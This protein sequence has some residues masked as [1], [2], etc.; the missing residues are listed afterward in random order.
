MT[1][2]RRKLIQLSALGGGLSV[3]GSPLLAA[4]R[5]NGPVAK[6]PRRRV[7]RR[8]I[9]LDF[10]T[11][12]YLPD[13]GKNFSKEQFQHSLKLANVDAVN[14]FAKGHHSWSYYP[15]KVGR[16]H[17][18]LKFDLLGEQIQACHEIGVAA[19]IYY[20]FGWS[21]N[22]AVNHPEWC[23]RLEDG[24]FQT[25][26]DFNWD[27]KPNDSKP[28]FHWI[29][30]CVNTSYH[31]H[32]MAQVEELCVNYEV[33]GLWLDIYQVS[34]PCYC[35]TC[36]K[37]MRAEGIDVSKESDVIAFLARSFKRHQGALTR[38]IQSYHPTATVYFNGCSA[39]NR[40][41]HNFKYE[42]YEYNTV[43]DLEDLPTTW[44]GYD[45]L[46]IQSKFFINA[47]YP[48][49]AMSGKFHTAWG[50]FGGF[51]SR[52]ALRYE[53]SAMIS[54]GA[55]C[56]FGDQLHP[57]G[58]MDLDTYKNIGEAY[59][60][61]E[62]IEDYGIGGTPEARVGVWR[63]FSASHDEGTCRILLER[64][65]NFDIANV[66]DRDLTAYDV[67]VIP[68]VAC[69]SANDARRIKAFIATGGSILVMGA[70]A[71]DS[72]NQ[73]LVVDIGARLVGESQYD[74]DYL[75][76][77]KALGDG[78]VESPFLC[79]EPALRVTAA[80]DTEVL[81]AVREPYFS[82][83]YEKFTSHQNTPFQL[84]DAP[85][86]GV[87]RKGNV[88]FIAHALDKMYFDHG[89]RL[90]RDLFINA[91]RLV[92]RRPMIETELPS[93]GRVSLLHQQDK[94]RFVV[95][96]LYGPPITRGNCE[97]IE[98][99]PTLHSVPVVLDL[100]KTITRA[101]LVPEM[102][103]LSVERVGQKIKVVVPQFS[104]HCA[105]ALDYA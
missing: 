90:H 72:K 51:K 80:A 104:C 1:I 21:H 99:L 9:H 73:S 43:Q 62:R 13:V 32:V 58:K 61:V 56:N 78:L 66:G 102:T 44:G 27:A 92:Y 8:Q 33:D 24:S 6:M 28:D 47:G 19:P 83:T 52:N 5:D 79:Y 50:E 34:R 65:V 84:E 4:G 85:Y 42:M 25:S 37:M 16:M 18:N 26:G 68:G 97:V 81:A 87:I 101:T 30:M 40:G 38:L 93:A 94:K 76:V 91:L 2:T 69:L 3:I 39:L 22:D 88:V 60:Y 41:S 86:P 53:A 15:T 49:T 31:E 23:S 36:R 103:P 48:I 12:E 64:H 71:L 82:R 100:P 63:S 11:S 54:W 59:R 17:P 29:F 77:N 7:G 95:H 67:I 10:H 74:K 75:V 45:K 57:S 20:T 105:I 89:A 55:N 98:D 35:E 46:P 70:G 14:V 96:L